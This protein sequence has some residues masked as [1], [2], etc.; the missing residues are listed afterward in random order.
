MPSSQSRQPCQA[1]SY[2][3]DISVCTMRDSIHSYFFMDV[4]VIS[5]RYAVRVKQ[6]GTIIAPKRTCFL[7]DRS[8]WCCKFEGVDVGRTRASWLFDDLS[9]NRFVDIN[10][11]IQVPIFN[12]APE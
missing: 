11:P 4:S 7:R 5:L 12:D 2:V 1:A 10:M 3:V 8:C 6:A 9:K